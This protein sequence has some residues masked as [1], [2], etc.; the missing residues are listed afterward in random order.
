MAPI[1]VPVKTIDLMKEPHRTGDQHLFGA[2]LPDKHKAWLIYILPHWRGRCV[3]V[4]LGNH[5]EGYKTRSDSVAPLAIAFPPI[6]P[7][8][9]FWLIEELLISLIQIL[10]KA[11]KSRLGRTCKDFF[12]LTVKHV[13][14]NVRFSDLLI[15]LSK[16]ARKL[17]LGTSQTVSPRVSLRPRSDD[18]M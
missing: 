13:W 9:Q 12:A 3:P 6:T 17:Y 5:H 15:V 7:M 18:H 16:D 8:H 4:A 10:N 2:Q 14:E 1:H 11:D